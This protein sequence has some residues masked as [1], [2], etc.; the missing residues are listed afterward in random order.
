MLP[1]DF[2]CTLTQ[3]DL[4][5]GIVGLNSTFLQLTKKWP[6]V[7]DHEGIQLPDDRRTRTFSIRVGKIKPPPTIQL[8]ALPPPSDKAKELF[9][10]VIAKITSILDSHPSLRD[11]LEKAPK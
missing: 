3:G 1:G 6:L 10:G 9:Q 2:S 4:R 11:E 7:P 5:L 8:A